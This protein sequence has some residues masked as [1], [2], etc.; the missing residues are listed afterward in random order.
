MLYVMAIVVCV[1]SAALGVDFLRSAERSHR[2]A[3]K[4]VRET[5]P[6]P[7]A[8]G[9]PGEI[10][11]F[12]GVIDSDDVVPCPSGGAA[13]ALVIA[14]LQRPRGGEGSDD[15]VLGQ[16]VLGPEV[17][18]SDATG[19]A[20]VE[21]KHVTLVAPVRKQHGA[22]RVPE[23]FRSMATRDGGAVRY[24]ELVVRRGD[25]A[26]VRGTVL[27][28]TDDTAATTGRGYREAARPAIRVGGPVTIIAYDLARM[29]RDAW[30]ALAIG[31]G[32][33]AFGLIVLGLGVSG[34][35]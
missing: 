24:Q 8:S 20:I 4:H 17:R 23:P 30:R 5:E 1:V 27:A 2:I 13:A 33:I 9:A 11:D 25:R 15:E 19:T 28:A 35:R 12:E 32:L 26:R 21:T 6:S 3:R 14:T 18:V 34:G 7:I 22:A 16:E 31:A 10:I 29:R